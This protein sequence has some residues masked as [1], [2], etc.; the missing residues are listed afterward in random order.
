MLLAHLQCAQ[1]LTRGPTQGPVVHGH[2][3][4]GTLCPPSP[5]PCPPPQAWPQELLSHELVMAE[6]RG[7]APWQYSWAVLNGAAP[8][9][10]SPL[11]RTTP[12]RSSLPRT[13]ITGG[14]PRAATAAAIAATAQQEASPVASPLG[15]AAGAKTDSHIA[16]AGVA[17]GAVAGSGGAEA[18]SSPAREATARGPTVGTSSADFSVVVHVDGPAPLRTDVPAQPLE[19]SGEA[20][21]GA[22]RPGNAG[23]D[24]GVAEPAGLVGAGAGEASGAVGVSPRAAE[25]FAAPDSP[26]GRP[27][28][29][30]P[31]PAKPG[32]RLKVGIDMGKV[33]ATVVPLTGRIHY[34]GKVGGVAPKSA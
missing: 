25:P 8:P 20:A 17:A 30:Q 2:D 13:S 14:S 6:E 29:Q 21:K 3:F 15:A 27:V 9:P 7:P 28:V 1:T 23:K 10:E 26:A 18:A 32:L 34:R 5:P 4:S 16:G 12:R 11:T 31:V 19:G 24:N 22:Y 33:A